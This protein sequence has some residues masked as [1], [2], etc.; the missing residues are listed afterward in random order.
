MRYLL[1]IK[2]LIL[3][4]RIWP[5]DIRLSIQTGSILSIVYGMSNTSCEFQKV[6]EQNYSILMRVLMGRRPVLYE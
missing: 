4:L 2:L 1:I 3:H 6:V 5:K